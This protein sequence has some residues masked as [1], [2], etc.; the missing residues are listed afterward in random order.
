[1][2]INLVLRKYEHEEGIQRLMGVTSLSYDNF[3]TSIE[4][5]QNVT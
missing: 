4:E 1:M 3:N 5:M 2:N